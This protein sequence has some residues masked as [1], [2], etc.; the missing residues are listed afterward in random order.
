VILVDIGI[1]PIGS[2]NQFSFKH[3][4]FL[5]RKLV[6]WHHPIGGE[7][8][9]SSLRLCHITWLK[10]KQASYGKKS[11]CSHSSTFSHNQPSPT[12]SKL[13][14]RSWCCSF[15]YK[16]S[17]ESIRLIPPTIPKDSNQ[18]HQGL[19]QLP[20]LKQKQTRPAELSQNLTRPAERS[21]NLGFWIIGC[22]EMDIGVC[23]VQSIF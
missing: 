20:V 13:E 10:L 14:S 17:P 8:C 23:D 9:L 3:N 1:Y 6:M 7:S 19:K 18:V 5:H 12:Q 2:H 4:W 16:Q 11:W 22:L 15:A 21:Q